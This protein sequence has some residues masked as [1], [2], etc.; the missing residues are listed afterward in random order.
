MSIETKIRKLG[1]TKIVTFPKAIM[2]YLKAN[3]GSSISLHVLDGAMIRKTIS[4]DSMTLESLIAN[5][6][7]ECFKATDEDKKWLS[8]KPVG[9]EFK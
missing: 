6:P 8:A 2:K 7:K 5:S 4:S 3:V 9:V 1:G